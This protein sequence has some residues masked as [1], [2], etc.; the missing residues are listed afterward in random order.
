MTFTYEWL[1]YE[2]VVGCVKGSRMLYPTACICNSSVR[3]NAD[4]KWVVQLNLHVL[5]KWLTITQNSFGLIPCRVFSTLNTVP[6]KPSQCQLFFGVKKV[7]FLR[8]FIK[9]QAY[10]TQQFSR[11]QIFLQVLTWVLKD[12][13][14]F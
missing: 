7:Q 6:T 2:M 14:L 5:L 9:K 11:N 8:N 1:E 4:S 10:F 12:H 3:L 13:Q